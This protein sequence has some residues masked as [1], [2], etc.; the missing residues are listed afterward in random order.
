MLFKNR[1]HPVVIKMPSV[2]GIYT[3]QTSCRY[4]LGHIFFDGCAFTLLARLYLLS[5]ESLDLLKLLEDQSD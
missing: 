1:W 4:R 3:L 2:T 5:I